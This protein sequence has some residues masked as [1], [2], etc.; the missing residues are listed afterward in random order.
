[1]RADA[2]YRLAVVGDCCADRDPDL[3]AALIERYF[4]RMATVMDAAGFCEAAAQ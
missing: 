3:H 4:P 1:M 2:D